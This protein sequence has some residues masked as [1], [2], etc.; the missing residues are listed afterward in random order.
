[1]IVRF[2]SCFL[3]VLV[4]GS[5]AAAGDCIKDSYGNVVCGKGQCALDQYGKVFCAKEGGGAVRDRSGAVRCGVGFCATDSMGEVMCSTK[6][7]GGAALDSYGNV[8]CLE[9]C[10]AATPQLCEAPR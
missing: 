1:M 8:K 10:R 6:P 7:G 2:L 9:S 4:M 3:L 5:A